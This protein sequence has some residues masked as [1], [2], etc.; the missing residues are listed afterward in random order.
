MGAVLWL[1]SGEADRADVLLPQLAAGS[2]ADVPRD[3]Y[4]LVTVTGLT[5]VAA[6]TGALDLAAEGVALL[7]PDAGRGV[8]D[9]GGVLF[10]GVLDD[11]LFRALLALGRAD[12]AEFRRLAAVQAYRRTGAAWWLRR[13]SRVIPAL[14]PAD[15]VHLHP[16]GTGLWAVGRH[17]ST[18]VVPDMKGLRYLCPLLTHPGADVPAL[19]LSDAVA[20]HAGVRVA[21]GDAGP[22]I[23]RQALAAYW[24]R[25][26][27]LDEELAEADSCGAAG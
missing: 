21:D 17:G 19:D 25:L 7:E 11:Y 14:H 20:G 4:W 13:G 10:L 16:D 15:V 26:A 18:H 12:E 5:E 1:D 6:A 24:H 8:V 22:V 9:D 27:E 2:L 3:V 23:D